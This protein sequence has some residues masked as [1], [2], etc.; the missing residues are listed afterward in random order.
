MTER[1]WE[2]TDRFRDM[3]AFLADPSGRPPRARRIGETIVA[4]FA[5]PAGSIDPRP[6]GVLGEAI[7]AVA[8]RLFGRAATPPPP[9]AASDRKFRLLTVA[10]CRFLW[11]T[12][13][14]PFADLPLY[15]DQGWLERIE[16]MADGD[17]TPADAAAIE[18]Y[19]RPLAHAFSGDEIPLR[20]GLLD[21][22]RLLWQ[23]AVGTPMVPMF[24]WFFPQPSAL[25]CEL[26]RD[27]VG[28]PFRPAPFDPRWRTAAATELAR[29]AYESRDFGALPI[30]ADALQ[31]AGCEDAEVL[32]HCRAG[33]PHVRGCW[34]V[35]GVLGKE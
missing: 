24:E 6:P 11:R 10:C 14:L 2:T 16:R 23:F 3:V 27:I 19:R 35:D 7:R 20:F 5:P 28:N 32:A 33:G 29:A 26:V 18:E 4:A 34:V 30:L 8:G 9:V 13:H 17:L 1:E 22:P 15:R 25:G 21:P 31:E 12:A